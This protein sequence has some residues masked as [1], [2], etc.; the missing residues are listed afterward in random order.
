M[1]VCRVVIIIVIACGLYGQFNTFISTG[2]SFC[3]ADI[4]GFL[5]NPSEELLQ[6]WY[7]AAVWLPFFRQHSSSNTNRREPYLYNDD[8]Q[9]VIRTAIQLRYFHLPYWYT[10]FYEHYRTGEPVIRPLIYAYPSDANVLDIDNEWLVG[11][12]ILVRP[13]IEENAQQVSVYFPGGTNQLWYD[14]E[15]TLLYRGSGFINID[16]SISSNVYFY[17]GGS[18]VPRR[19]TARHSSVETLGDPVTVYVF[20]ND[21]GE[22]SGTLYVDDTTTFEYR[23]KK[24]WYLEFDFSNNTLSTDI[25]DPDAAYDETVNFGNTIVYRPPSG[26]KGAQIFESARLVKTLAVSYGPEEKYLNIDN[27]NVPLNKPFSIKLI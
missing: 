14:V 21:N 16:V 3:G 8:V 27:I 6:K 19:N 17:R 15:N 23:N 1:Y 18:I 22:A 10:V 11:E 12:N 13:A 5:N 26:I 9:T 2:L 7:Q 20:L 25:I 4:G 24:Y